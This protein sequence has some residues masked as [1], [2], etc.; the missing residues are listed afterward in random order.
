MEDDDDEVL[1]FTMYGNGF[2]IIAQNREGSRLSC[3]SANLHRMVLRRTRRIRPNLR[4]S[5]A[6]L[7]EAVTEV[8]GE[9]KP[10]VVRQARPC[11]AG[12]NRTCSI[13]RSQQPPTRRSARRNFSKFERGTGA[14]WRRRRSRRRLAVIT[15][16]MSR[17]LIHFSQSDGRPVPTHFFHRVTHFLFAPPPA[18]V[19]ISSDACRPPAPLHRT[20]KC[21]WLVGTTEEQWVP[22]KNQTQNGYGARNVYCSSDATFRF[23]IWHV[24]APDLVHPPPRSVSAPACLDYLSDGYLS[25]GNSV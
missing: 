18:T 15:Y 16:E 14:G 22:Q 19:K 20:T 1:M 7:T 11:G 6:N 12:N 17:R 4:I 3:E 5:R 9:Q 2:V 23:C 24:G 13:Q 8:E 10:S 25:G 21:G